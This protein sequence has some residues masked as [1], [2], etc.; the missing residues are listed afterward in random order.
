MA[1]LRN[2]LQQ[3][4]IP[5]TTIHHNTGNKMRLI[6]VNIMLVNYI[7]YKV[8]DIKPK[9]TTP[10]Q[11]Q[12]EAQQE[13]KP[14]VI[15]RIENGPRK[16]REISPQFRRLEE[17]YRPSKQDKYLYENYGDFPLEEEGI[18]MK[19]TINSNDRA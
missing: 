11:T 14:S 8:K 6:P 7:K 12:Q 18:K 2:L 13:T 19:L 3:A 15:K 10:Q 17:I 16:E 9:M 1:L 5:F 4:N